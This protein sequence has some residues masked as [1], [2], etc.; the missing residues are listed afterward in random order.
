MERLAL[1]WRIQAEITERTDAGQER[2][3]VGL[4]LCAGSAGASLFGDC[5]AAG[6]H[7]TNSSAATGAS[8]GRV[9]LPAGAGRE[10]T[11]ARDRFH[12]LRTQHPCPAAGRD[13]GAARASGD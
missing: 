5:P 11:P 12:V 8:V 3:C 7:L 10:G 1:R 2:S 4:W 9:S 13:V 6:A